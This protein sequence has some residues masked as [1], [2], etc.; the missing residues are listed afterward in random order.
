VAEGLGHS[1]CA[2]SDDATVIYLCSTVYTPAA[3]HGIHPLD[4]ALG[5]PWPEGLELVLSD[6]DAA[7]PTLAQALAAGGLPRVE[8]C[9]TGATSGTGVVR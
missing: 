7:A 1:F 9:T 6:K 2:L 5:L 3:E 8:N 4:P